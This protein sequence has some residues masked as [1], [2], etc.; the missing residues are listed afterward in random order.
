MSYPNRATRAALGPHFKNA[1][2]V[3]HPETDA[4]EET[5]NPLCDQVAG[6]NQVVVARA[7]LVANWNGADFDKATQTEAWN[8][9]GNQAHPVLARAGAGVYSYTFA[10]TYLNSAGV[11]VPIAL[12]A[13][14]VSSHKVLTAFSE[15]IDA[16]AF[17]DVATNPLV[18]QIRLWDATGTPEDAPFWL[19]VG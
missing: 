2:P 9:D 4:G 11:A 16:Y 5:L 13:P 15:R 19:E 3:E 7:A 1:H 8:P 10:G 18:V 17:I 6:L 12:V 14:R